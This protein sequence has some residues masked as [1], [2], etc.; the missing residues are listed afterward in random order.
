[1]HRAP[2]LLHDLPDN[3][4]KL[5]IRQSDILIS[6]NSG[7]TESSFTSNAKKSKPCWHCPELFR[8]SRRNTVQHAFRADVLI[9]IR[10]M[11]TLA[12]SDYLEMS[13]LFRSS[14]GQ[15]P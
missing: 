12:V 15:T 11:H 14:L 1:V 9:D 5:L 3:P 7:A 6:L 4:V 10:P 8:L 13:A 2:F